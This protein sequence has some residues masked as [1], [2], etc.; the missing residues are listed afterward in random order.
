MPLDAEYEYNCQM[1]FKNIKQD[2]NMQFVF[3]DGKI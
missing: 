2:M 1:L 3:L